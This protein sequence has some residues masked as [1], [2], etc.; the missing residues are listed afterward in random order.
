[1]IWIR[2][3][4]EGCGRR[5]H[6][7]LANSAPTC[8]DVGATCT[9]CDTRN[10]RAVW[11][12]DPHPDEAPRIGDSRRVITWR[13]TACASTHEVVFTVG[14]ARSVQSFRCARCGAF[15]SVVLDLDAPAGVGGSTRGS[16]GVLL[17]CRYCEK[18]WITPATVED[19]GR[20]LRSVCPTCS[21]VAEVVVPD[22]KSAAS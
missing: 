17:S 21:T 8:R 7:P 13:C 16:F 19:A 18:E 1:M 4:C 20:S 5:N 6:T 15:Q 22:A 12:I 14:T 9:A 11:E 10:A 2:W 3:L